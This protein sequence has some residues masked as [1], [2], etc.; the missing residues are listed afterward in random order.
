MLNDFFN[1]LFVPGRT[2]IDV[3][4]QILSVSHAASHHRFVRQVM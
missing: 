3:K 2:L 4:L 1:G